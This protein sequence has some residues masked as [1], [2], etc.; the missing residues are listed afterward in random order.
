M[1]YDPKWEQQAETR[2]KPSLAGLI[3]WLETQDPAEPY[4]YSCIDGSCLID[5]YLTYATGKPSLPD[6]ATHWP[7]CGGA[8]NYWNIASPWPQTFG[9]ALERARKIT[10]AR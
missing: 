3:A 5:Q 6:P 8:D 9:A 2:A 7:V 1:L 10:A 4:R